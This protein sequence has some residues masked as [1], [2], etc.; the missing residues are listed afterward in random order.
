[1]YLFIPATYFFF[2]Y[3]YQNPK[4]LNKA[5]RFSINPYEKRLAYLLMSDIYRD[6]KD[7]NK[8]IEFLEKS[9]QK[10]YL[11]YPL[12]TNLLLYFYSIKGDYGKTLEISSILNKK[13]GIALR[14]IY[15]MNNEYEKAL[16]TFTNGANNNKYLFLEADL[17]MKLG[18]T[19]EAT[20]TKKDA[21]KFYKTQL[22]SY[23]DYSKQIN[24]IENSKKYSS[25]S[26]YKIYLKEQAKEY[27]FD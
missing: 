18:K 14:N 6:K 20:K 27:K 1:M 26:S 19:E 5:V 2:G 9:L 3:S 4:L 16:T 22:E 12:E 11:K 17:L 21:E 8:A 23:S 24:F 7:G 15:I 10:Q 25:I 13:Q